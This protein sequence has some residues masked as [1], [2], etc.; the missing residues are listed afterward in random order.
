MLHKE[1]VNWIQQKAIDINDGD[2]NHE[3]NWWYQC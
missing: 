1:A 3:K 2:D